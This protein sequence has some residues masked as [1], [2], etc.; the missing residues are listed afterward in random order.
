M[1][2]AVLPTGESLQ[3]EKTTKP[4]LALRGVGK[5]QAEV[6]LESGRISVNARFGMEPAYARFSASGRTVAELHPRGV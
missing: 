4:S 3:K 6:W 2:W 1:A 5:S